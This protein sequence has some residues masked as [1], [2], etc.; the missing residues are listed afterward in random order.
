MSQY[1]ITSVY[2]GVSTTIEPDFGFYY[3][4]NLNE[5]NECELKFSSMSKTIRAC[6]Q[7]G[8]LVEILRDSTRE[9]YGL[10][11]SIDYIDGG[12]LIVHAS[13][14]EIWLAK[15]HGAYSNSPW[16]STASATIFSSLI[17]ESTH[18]TAGT[19]A[20]GLNVDFK[21]STSDSLFNS[22]SELLKKTGQD[23]EL[24]YSNTASIKINITDHKGSSTSKGV[25]NGGIDFYNLKYTTIY[26]TG[27][28]V[29]V[30]G[31]GDGTNQIMSTS[32]HGQ[33]ITSQSTY[34]VIKRVV[35]DR[36]II[37]QDAANNLADKEVAISKDPQKLYS[38]T[39]NDIS[40]NLVAGDIITI[41][42]DDVGLNDEAVRIT[43]VKRGNKDNDEFL[44]LLVTN[45]AHAILIKDYRRQLNDIRKSVRDTT[46]YMQGSGNLSQWEGIRNANNSVGLKVPFYI[47]GRFLDEAGVLRIDSITVDFDVDPYNKEYGAVS[48]DQKDPSIDNSTFSSDDNESTLVAE[49]DT[50]N[51]SGTLRNTWTTYWDINNVA[52]HGEAIIFHVH[53][54]VY[55][56]DTPGH[57]G[58]IYARI[59]HVDEADYYPSSIGLRIAR[60][61]DEDTQTTSSDSHFHSPPAGETYFMYSDACST[62]DACS[63]G[64]GSDS[65]THTL[66]YFPVTEGTCT[67]YVPIDPYLQDFDVQMDTTDS[68]GGNAL[69]TWFFSYYVVS[70]HEHGD[71]DYKTDNHDHNVSIGDGV[72]DAGS[73]NATNVTIY[74]QKWNTG[75]SV[76]DTLVTYTPSPAKTLGYDIDMSSSGTYPASEGWYRIRIITNS[77]SPDLV[78]AVV[79][80]KHNLDN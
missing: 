61:E 36:T 65:H 12:G 42:S 73:L 13:G 50:T 10:V 30:Y 41:T 46:T 44:S 11:D 77:A 32:A 71:G 18:L 2:G 6:L 45:S 17:G 40:W 76:W 67:I 21:A 74:L 19:I 23:Y 16:N 58:S 1:R 80:V 53:C 56:W 57:T 43:Q 60:G 49:N 14:Y 69:A 72:S 70:Q 52:V 68:S 63:T 59:Y 38:L 48:E 15:E 27:N 51:S 64:T 8:A 4:D 25:L 3:T 34:G 47:G 31:K 37:S 28:Y 33:D 75:T 26:P 22:I 35:V 55:Q 9:F 24:D 7:I 79:S 66:R 20:T 54:R 5:I 78:M 29:V 62:W 39:V